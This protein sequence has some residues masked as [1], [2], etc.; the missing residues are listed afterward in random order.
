[1][2]PYP[3]GAL[4]IGHLRNYTIS[5]V[6]ARYRRMCGHDVLH[7]IGWDAF[8]LPAE[9]AAIDRGIPP[10]EWTQQNI[11]KMRGQIEAMGGCWD[12]DKELMTC[13]PDFYQ[14]TQRLFLSLY[15]SGLAYQAEAVVNW[16]PIDRTVL[17]NEQVDG[18]GFSWR[19]GAR[20]EQRKLSQ[21]F[22]GITRY[23]D[24]LLEDLNSLESGKQWPS[25]VTAMQRNWLG[26]SEGTNVRFELKPRSGIAIPDLASD[27]HVF[28]TR[29][30]TLFGVQYIALSTEHSLVQHVRKN[31]AH[32]DSFLAQVPDLPSDSKAGFKLSQ[33]HACN[34][35][36][37]IMEN[38]NGCM[39]LPVFVAPYV[40]SDYGSGAVMGVPAHDT[41]D[42]AFWKQ[43]AATLPRQVVVPTRDAQ[44][45]PSVEAAF[46]D[47][48][49]LTDECGAYGGMESGTA[50]EQI[51]TDLAA[52]DPALAVRCTKW[53]LRD[54]LISRQRYWGCPI[55]I[56]HC[57][58]CGS[59]PVPERDLPVQLP[60]LDKTLWKDATGNPLEKDDQWC[61]VSCPNCGQSARRETDTMDT[62]MDSSWYY[63][64][65]A[66][67]A[68]RQKQ[69]SFLPVDLY[70][71]GVEH[72]IL[73]LLYAR[74]IYKFLNA[75]SVQP[76]RHAE[77]FQRLLTQGMV[78]G[79]TFSD[80][81]TGRFLKPGDVDISDPNKPRVLSSDKIANI[82]YAKMSKS[83]YNGVDPLQC[84]QKYGADV[85]R[86]HLLFQ[87]PPTE[88]LEWDEDKIVG[89]QRWFGRIW[90]LTCELSSFNESLQKQSV[91][92]Q[93]DAEIEL[94]RSVQ[95]T[96]I[97]VHE[98]FADTFALNTV[99]SDL[100]T[101]TNDIQDAERHT[102]E[103]R[104]APSI[105][106]QSLSVLLRLLVPIAPSFAEE[107]WAILHHHQSFAVEQTASVAGFPEP[108]G[109][110]EELQARTQPCAVQVNGKL[111]FVLDIPIP[112]PELSQEALKHWILPGLVR[113]EQWTALSMKMGWDIDSAQRIIAVRGGRTINLVL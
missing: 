6:I 113:S 33:V 77:P 83:K 46:T 73:H 50:S 90:N 84:M 80:P 15:K 93:I 63:V 44:L 5:D 12:W 25:H 58:S 61:T 14:D 54:W 21:W 8:G 96:I 2:F 99:V 23:A 95:A 100:M 107:C 60:K 59:V 89:V 17:A 53:R 9:N 86:A 88:I 18:S 38:E 79:K 51:L 65:F 72:A 40:R 81:K 36:A 62:F 76:L 68:G 43:H 82:T 111:K 91:N 16:D 85:T 75:H 4:H 34:P 28:T 42:F 41:R 10:P 102:S 98:S 7:P 55:P 13:S 37:F 94:W 27:V 3:S 101:L 26:R 70:I 22:L 78:H 11:D 32:L 48:G 35:L 108:D 20:V 97:S 92:P 24:R 110:L 57:S 1:M 103:S 30:D 104:L 109:S 49:F 56:I 52:R 64:R 19:S 87:A 66:D 105:M 47:A 31:D 67:H 45:S 71:G 69:S 29:L 39:D 106:T 74:F 112:P